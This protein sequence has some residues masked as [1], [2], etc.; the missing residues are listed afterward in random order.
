MKIKRGKEE[1]DDEGNNQRTKMKEK[2]LTETR[3]RGN[4]KAGKR[5]MKRDTK[6]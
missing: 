3:H 1:A 2:Q 6:N 5:K 4:R